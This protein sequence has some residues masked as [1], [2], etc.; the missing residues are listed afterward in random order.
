MAK[1]PLML[2]TLLLNPDLA[3]PSLPLC[4]SLRLRHE[5]PQKNIKVQRP[6]CPDTMI[7]P[8]SRFPRSTSQ[9]PLPPPY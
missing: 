5:P 3:L 1:Y 4:L 7:R 8:R 2:P 6:L 9:K